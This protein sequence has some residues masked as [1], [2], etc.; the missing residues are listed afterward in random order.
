MPLT[1]GETPQTILGSAIK[2]SEA[3][4]SYTSDSLSFKGAL[5]SPGFG[6]AG[7]WGIR[8]GSQTGSIWG[9]QHEDLFP[10]TCT[11]PLSGVRYNGLLSDKS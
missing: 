9:L 4:I 5:N 7:S 11:P 1:Q 2:V 8:G 6:G 3:G 10:I